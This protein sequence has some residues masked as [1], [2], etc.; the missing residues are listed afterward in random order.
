MKYSPLSTHEH[1]DEDADMDTHI[2]AE[3]QTAVTGAACQPF[4]HAFICSTPFIR[5]LVVVYIMLAAFCVCFILPFLESSRRH[6]LATGRH[7]GVAL[8][9]N[10]Q[11]MADVFPGAPWRTSQ[12]VSST[13]LLSTPRVRVES[14]T[15]RGEDGKEYPDWIWMDVTDHVNVIPFTMPTQQE[16]NEMERKKRA[17]NSDRNDALMTGSITS[18]RS[19]TP[20][21]TPPSYH[22]ANRYRYGTFHLFRQRKYGLLNESLA[23]AGGQVETQRNESPLEAA[24]RELEE[25]MYYIAPDSSWLALGTYRVNVNRG[26]GMVSCFLVIDPV[27]QRMMKK[28]KQPT[29]TAGETDSGTNTGSAPSDDDDSSIFHID[30][31]ERQTRVRLS[32]DEMRRAVDQQEVAEIKWMAT[33][34]MALREVEKRIAEEDDIIRKEARMEKSSRQQAA[35]SDAHG[36]G[37]L[38]ERTFSHD[39][40]AMDD[41]ESVAPTQA[42]DQQS[43]AL[44]DSPARLTTSVTS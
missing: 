3:A 14:H 5:F 10:P 35:M 8:V 21:P 17:D 38:P 4:K 34:V 7:E 44:Q 9:Q 37:A 30:E 13:L 22:R 41:S 20:Q 23:V 24:K 12:T 6:E 16:A 18:P 19:S 33:A 1:A 39:Q 42:L 15:V 25:E 40:A 43:R 2:D 28:R 11:Q 29:A 32:V 26:H 27:D 31:L 36:I